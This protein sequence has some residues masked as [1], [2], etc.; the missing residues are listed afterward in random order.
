LQS[1]ID[2]LQQELSTSKGDL[3]KVKS[4]LEQSRLDLEA[5]RLA[6]EKQETIY[7]ELLTDLEKLRRSYTLSRRL[8]KILG[9]TSLAGACYIAVDVI[10]FW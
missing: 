1:Q 5:S 3:A 2:L 4:E 6:L 9:L 10:G 7:K 8:T